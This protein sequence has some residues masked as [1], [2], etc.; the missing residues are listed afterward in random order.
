MARLTLIF[1]KPQRET[2]PLPSE[3]I[4]QLVFDALAFALILV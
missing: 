1:R 3:N 2:G 4:D